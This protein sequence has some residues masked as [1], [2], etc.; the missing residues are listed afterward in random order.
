MQLLSQLLDALGCK[1]LV[2]EGDFKLFFFVLGIILLKRERER[3]V[4]II[5]KREK[6]SVYVS[7]RIEK[8][9]L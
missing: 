5:Y 3:E 8:K 2:R 4:Q 7:G 1:V 9:K 6:Q